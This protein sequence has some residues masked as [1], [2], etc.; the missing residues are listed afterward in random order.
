MKVRMRDGTGERK[1]R[2]VVEDMDRH[3]NVRIYLRRRGQ[4]VRLRETPRTPEFDGRRP[5]AY[6]RSIISER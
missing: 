2:Y 6:A 3:G 5:V 1:Y 4:K